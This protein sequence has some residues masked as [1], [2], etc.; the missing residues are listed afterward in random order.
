M[1]KTMDISTGESNHTYENIGKRFEGLASLHK[2]KEP[3]AN[4][5]YEIISK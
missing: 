2:Q 5:N 4:T 1:K 3:K